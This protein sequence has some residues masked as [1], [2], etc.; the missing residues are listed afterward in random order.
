MNAQDYNN[1]SVNGYQISFI[2]S[3][4]NCGV[5]ESGKL[6]IEVDSFA[7]VKLRYLDAN[8]PDC[9]QAKSWNGVTDVNYDSELNLIKGTVAVYMPDGVQYVVRP[10]VITMDR[11]WP[12]ELRY[13]RIHVYV[14][15]KKDAGGNSPE[16][17]SFT[18]DDR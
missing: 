5:S 12:L 1:D 6:K 3:P 7:K 17:G 9:P 4:E 8:G 13:K 16:D 11:R 18:G 10:F 2:Q 14:G 15:K